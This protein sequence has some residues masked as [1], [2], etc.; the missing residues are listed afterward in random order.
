MRISRNKIFN[1]LVFITFFAVMIYEFLTPIMSD[2]IVY[3]DAVREAGSFFDLFSQEYEHYIGHTGRSVA[4][5]ILRI[6]F[7]TGNKAIYNVFAAGAFTVLSLLIYKNIEGKKEFDV[8]AYMVVVLLLWFFDPAISNTVF[9][10]TGACNYLFTTTLIMGF[11]TTYRFG[12]KEKRDNTIGLT[13]GM[14][15]Y[16]I[17]CGWCNENTS[18]GLILFVLITLFYN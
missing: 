9:W 15:L 6:F 17:V 8:R 13:I 10:M 14:L 2:D 12:V 7:F 18:G 16:G 11:L 5:M 3:G 1:I 4:H